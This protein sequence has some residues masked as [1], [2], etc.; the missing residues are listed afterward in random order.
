[1]PVQSQ[2]T[3]NTRFKI[4]IAKQHPVSI[5]ENPCFISGLI[6]PLV[7][8]GI[9]LDMKYVFGPVPSRRLGMS[10]GVDIV[11]FKTCTFDCVY[12]QLS[13]TTK[14]S[15]DRDD[16]VPVDDVLAEIKEVIESG[17]HV[18][19]ITFSGSGEPTLN[20]KLGEMIRRVKAFTDTPIAVIT[21]G[22]LL[23][24]K[25]VR[26]DLNEADLVVPSL[27]AISD[28]SFSKVNRPHN[29]ITAKMLIDGLRKFAHNYRGKLWLEIMI[30][31][32]IN[33]N[34]DELK[35]IA[36]I[37]REFRLDKIQLNTVVR[38][39][40][41][42]FAMP[43]TLVEMHEI[44]GLFDDRVEV[45]ADFDKIPK[46]VSYNE[47]SIEDRIVALVKRRPCTA[48]DISS[49]LGLHKI[50]VIKHVDHLLRAGSIDQTNRDGRV[51]YK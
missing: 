44:A 47:E 22:S 11:P 1:L 45:I 38:P 43:L 50:E 20:S 24:K 7:F 17:K 10:L 39:P 33:D 29:D 32:G 40:A 30:V 9:F 19:F 4:Q 36:D 42:D 5:R 26:D 31:K 34:R 21:N 12:C 25:D 18:D 13:V 8:E 2:R 49:S 37:I 14:K 51:Y 23:Y 15:V 41:E 46:H 3:K 28:A 27:D 48:D 6:F 35:Q 16:F